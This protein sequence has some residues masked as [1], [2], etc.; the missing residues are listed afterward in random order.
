MSINLK[1]VYDIAS[2]IYNILLGKYKL[3]NADFLV[4]EKMKKHDKH[5]L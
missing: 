1:F 2:G 3:Q 5:K 4:D